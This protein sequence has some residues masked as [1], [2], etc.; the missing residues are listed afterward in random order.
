MADSEAQFK[1]KY[2]SRAR[3]KAIKRE[4]CANCGAT[5]SVN[6]H[7]PPKGR[8]GGVGYKASWR[9]VVPLCDA[10]HRVRDEECGSNTAF[11]ARTSLDLTRAA[12]WFAENYHPDR[13]PSDDLDF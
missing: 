5:P 1:R 2:G 3:A 7:C 10:C 4:P 12:K 11:F 8:G 9:W 13:L 6:A